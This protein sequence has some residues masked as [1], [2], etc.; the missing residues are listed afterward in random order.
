MRGF[1]LTRSM[2]LSVTMIGA[3]LAVFAAASTFAAFTSS[4]TDS[5][6]VT[7]GTATIRLQGTAATPG[8]ITFGP[9]AAGCPVN[10]APGNSCVA[11]VTVTNEGSLAVVLT[12]DPTTDIDVSTTD[13]VDPAGCTP[14]DWSASAGTFVDPNLDPGES[15]TFELTVTLD[16]AANNGCQGET[17]TVEVTVAAESA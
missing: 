8:E 12:P 7:A 3:V 6:T 15:T 13:T 11:T 16:G 5:G 9:G 4:D 17:A 10:L 14:A 1:A 2:L